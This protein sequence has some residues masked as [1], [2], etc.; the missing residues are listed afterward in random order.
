VHN[1]IS[2][3][4][5]GRDYAIEVLPVGRD[6]WRAQLAR[7]GSTTAVM[8]FYGPTPAEAAKQLASWLGRAGRTGKE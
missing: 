4:I 3:T 6:R 2:E 8:P 7:K 5:N 1:I